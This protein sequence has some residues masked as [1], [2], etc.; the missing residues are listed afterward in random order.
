MRGLTGLRPY[1]LEAGEV[2]RWR[3]VLELNELG[4]SMLMLDDF[5][6]GV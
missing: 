1:D 4:R 3:L 2:A 6:S 5:L